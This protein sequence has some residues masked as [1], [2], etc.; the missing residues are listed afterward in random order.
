MASL[1]EVRSARSGKLARLKELGRESYPITTTANIDAAGAVKRFATLVKSQKAVKIAGRV[2]AMRGQGAITFIDLVDDSGKLQVLAKEDDLGADAF[3]HLVETVDIGDWIEFSG[4]LFLTKRE[5][6]TLLAKSWTML[7]KSL[8]PLPDKW[9]GLQDVEER[10]RRRYLDSL[11]DPEVKKRFETRAKIIKGIR[12]YLDNEDYLEVE[13]PMLQAQAGGASAEPFKTHHNAL[14]L[15]LFLRISPELYLKRMLVGGFPRVYEL[16]RN[17]RNEGIDAT[18]NPEFTMLEFYEAFADAA[19]MRDR[20]ETLFKKLVKEIFGRSKFSY[21]GTMIDLTD[22]FRVITFYDLLKRHALIADPAI[23]TREELAL[24][25]SQFAI[26]IEPSDGREKILD[27]I[28]KKVCRPKL[29]QPTFVIDYPRDY[30][31]LAK[32]KL[33]NP[34]LVDAFQLIIGGLEVVKAF[35]ELNDPVDQAERFTAQEAKRKEGDKEAQT[36][37]KDYVEA[38]EYG[39]PPAGGVGIGIDR[40]TMLLTDTTNIREVIFFPLLRPKSD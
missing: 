26:K 32:A 9:H 13:T 4:S 6:K 31:P 36:F 11:M 2:M 21:Q 37:D 38:L 8:R 3:A 20:V 7:A 25:A 12:E 28:Y 33:E 27:A 29:I 23:A 34:A 19:A 35:S 5:E 18:H 17:F 39:M 30:L 14:E 22:S 24:K 16:G 10:F 1:D 15:D 40:L